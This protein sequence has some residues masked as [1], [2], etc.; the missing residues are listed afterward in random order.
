MQIS[1]DEVHRIKG[2]NTFYG[3]F[4]SGHTKYTRY[5]YTTLA[6]ATK[7]YDVLCKKASEDSVFIELIKYPGGEE[8]IFSNR[9]RSPYGT[10]RNVS[11]EK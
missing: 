6:E 4:R 3:V 9:K 11:M 7:K 10:Y 5:F 2:N 1:I 8:I